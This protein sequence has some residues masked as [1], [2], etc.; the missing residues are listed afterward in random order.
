MNSEKTTTNDGSSDKPLEP[1]N[2]TL[3][4]LKKN[5]KPCYDFSLSKKL[6]IALG[7]F[8]FCMSAFGYALFSRFYT[9]EANIWYSLRSLSKN[10]QTLQSKVDNLEQKYKDVK[11]LPTRFDEMNKRFEEYKLNNNDNDSN[12]QADEFMKLK[13]DISELSDKL[14]KIIDNQSS[15][16]VCDKSNQSWTE[17]LKSLFKDGISVTKISG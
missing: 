17:R 6:F 4:N 13:N 7:S 2:T 12:I 15:S 11:K 16:H 9:H 10:V 8:A 1:S 3:N 5:F 14:S